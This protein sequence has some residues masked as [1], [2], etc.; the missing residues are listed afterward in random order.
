LIARLQDPDLSAKELETLISH[1]IALSFKLLRYL[2]S[3]AVSLKFS[4]DSVAHAAQMVGTRRIRALACTIM[5]T[6]VEDKS[7]E[8]TV[9]AMV[10]ATMAERLAKALKLPKPDACF[11]IGLFSVVDA[12]L[13]TPMSKALEL[14]PLSDEVQQALI[15]QQGTMGL[16]L[17]CILA[18]EN[19][20]WSEARCDDLDIETISTCYLKSITDAR[21]LFSG[22]S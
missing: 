1:D 11:T 12:L 17:R 4:I 6:A 20:N 19:G 2:N 14:V 3:A 18:Y 10:R 8:L 9:T 5:L 16:I 15:H 22:L 13:D 21:D 7:R